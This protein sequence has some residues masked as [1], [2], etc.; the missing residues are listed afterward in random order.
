MP[1][2]FMLRCVSRCATPSSHALGT[3]ADCTI[4]RTRPPVESSHC[5]DAGAVALNRSSAIASSLNKL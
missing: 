5:T 1:P 4:P 3:S 2:Y